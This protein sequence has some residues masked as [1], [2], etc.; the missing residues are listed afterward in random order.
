MA[1]WSWSNSHPLRLRL[2]K[3]L[4]GR[5]PSTRGFPIFGL[6]EMSC[7]SF[8]SEGISRDPSRFCQQHRHGKKQ[9]KRRKRQCD[10]V[11]SHN[12]QRLRSNRTCLHG[13]RREKV[14]WILIPVQSDRKTQ[15]FEPQRY[16]YYRDLFGHCLQIVGFVCACVSPTITA[17]LR[18]HIK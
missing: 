13:W 5:Q 16:R 18:E 11:S 4:L 2:V 7:A 8:D 1:R 3:L 14:L 17:A 6:R 15:L 12:G 9:R 10:G